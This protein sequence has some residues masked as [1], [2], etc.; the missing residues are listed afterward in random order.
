MKPALVMDNAALTIL[1]SKIPSQL[2]GHFRVTAQDLEHPDTQNY[3]RKGLIEVALLWEQKGDRLSCRHLSELLDAEE[4]YSGVIQKLLSFE[5]QSG[6][7]VEANDFLYDLTSRKIPFSILENQNFLNGLLELYAANVPKYYLLPHNENPA[8]LQRVIELISDP[9][10]RKAY[11]EMKVG[12]RMVNVAYITDWRREM[13]THPNFIAN[14]RTVLKYSAFSVSEFTRYPNTLAVDKLEDFLN[15]VPKD[16]MWDAKRFIESVSSEP[17]HWNRAI[18]IAEKYK[19]NVPMLVTL[20]DLTG[21]KMLDHEYMALFESYAAERGNVMNERGPGTSATV[22]HMTLDERYLQQKTG[23]DIRGVVRDLNTF[24]R[25]Y[26]D[27]QTTEVTKEILDRF[28]SYALT[29]IILQMNDLHDGDVETRLK[30]IS[31]YDARTLLDIMTIGGSDA[32]LSTFRLMYN[33]NGNKG[34]V[35][36]H[37]FMYKVVQEYGS[38]Y[39]FLQKTNPLKR[40]VSRMLEHLSQNDLTDAFLTDLGTPDQ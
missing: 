21:K 1:L 29:G 34:G 38:L 13:Y 15:L 25:I 37:T 23:S 2:R 16:K 28:R 39:N 7:T 18:E 35:L 12:D 20:F 11:M 10:F 19:D 5:A 6:G 36:K 26:N 14:A 22:S 31:N 24:L 40:D 4:A 30:V 8:T 3:Q 33:G 32:F 17:S 27:P 9:D